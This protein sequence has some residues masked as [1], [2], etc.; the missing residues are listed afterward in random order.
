MNSAQI[1]LLVAAAG[2]TPIALSYGFNPQASLKFLFNITV[3]DV[4]LA[5]IFRAVMGLYGAFVV[6]WVIG[7]R[8][9][10]LTRPA[11]YSLVAFMSGLALGRAL[12]LVVDG[13]PHWLLFLYMVLEL[14][15][16]A[17]GIM[18]LKQLNTMEAVDEN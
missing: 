2:L 3:Q 5:H 6:F 7:A 4:N 10:A 18:M 16:S 9:S 13:M 12:S 1:F 15:F 11:L 8:N 17:V 14:G